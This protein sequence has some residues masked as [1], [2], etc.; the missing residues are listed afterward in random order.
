MTTPNTIGKSLGRTL[1]KTGIN[2]L[3]KSIPLTPTQISGTEARQLIQSYYSQAKVVL[4]DS[5][6]KIIPWKQW[7]EIDAEIYDITKKMY[8]KEFNDCDDRAYVTKYWTQRIFFVSQIIVHGHCYDKD[9]KW[10][11]GHFWNA[12]I[13]DDKLYYYEPIGNH[14]TEVK[15]GEKVWMKD[16]EYR[17]ITFEF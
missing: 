4:L 15:K 5:K 2:V 7:L 3:G 14:W 16:R 1:L 10:L 13:A 17:A 9:G 8:E 6:Y 11:F 12:R